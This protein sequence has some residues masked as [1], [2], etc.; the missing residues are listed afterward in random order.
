MYI[1]R[2]HA[3]DSAR[4][5]ESDIFGILPGPLGTGLDSPMDNRLVG[6]LLGAASRQHWS[7]TEAVDR[8]WFYVQLVACAAF[9]IS[10]DKLFGD[11]SADF[12]YGKNFMAWYV[13]WH[14]P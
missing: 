11:T 3:V 1:Y 8:W 5:P 9:G 4:G 13:N 6:G 12:L 14:F 2:S 7:H 10:H